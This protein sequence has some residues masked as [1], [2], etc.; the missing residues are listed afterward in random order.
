MTPARPL[1]AAR[2]FTLV[3]VLVSLLIL[4]V[5]AATAWKGMDAIGRAREVADGKLKET[6]RL[7]SVM[8]Q[9]EADMAQ[10]LDTQVVPA[11]E[12]DG[13]ALRLTRK[14]QSGV[15]VV[16][17]VSRDGRWLRWASPVVSR[18]GDLRTQWQRSYTLQGR[19]VGT[20]TALPG[21]VQW[22]VYCFR[23]GSLSNCQSSGN[24][25]AGTGSTA[26]VLLPEAIRLSLTLDERSGLPG[27]VQR[28]VMLAPQPN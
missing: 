19:E 14:A 1:D 15:I 13:G 22:Q 11:L 24:V 16:T 5:L 12:F 21:L 20:L 6:L 4:S 10:V 27:N 23:G 3:E 18:V 8:T 28:D 2:G 25:A 9:W 7:Q 17:W 26:R